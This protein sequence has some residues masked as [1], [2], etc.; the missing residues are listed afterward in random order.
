[1]PSRPPKAQPPGDH[2]P[3]CRRCT[4]KRCV[5]CAFHLQDS[6]TFSSVR[7]GCTYTIRD[8]VGCKNSNIIYLIDCA[9][10]GSM[11]YVGETGQTISRRMHGHRSDIGTGDTPRAADRPA[12]PTQDK[13]KRES[14]VA[15]HFQSNNHT[16]RDMKV[17]VIEQIREDSSSI[18]KTR[19][20]FWRHKLRTNYP[21]GLN[22]WD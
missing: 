4:A 6:T 12:V 5:L 20:R 11:Q 13:Y 1:M 22:V 9:R 10:C 3:G 7:T 15:K 19:E 2:P 17:L 14:L 18:R 16:V 21:Q 8:P